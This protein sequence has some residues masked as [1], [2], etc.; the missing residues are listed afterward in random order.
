MLKF[1]QYLNEHIFKPKRIEDR[2]AFLKKIDVEYQESIKDKIFTF[3]LNFAYQYNSDDL[4]KVV[5]LAKK[6]KIKVADHTEE[7]Y[8]TSVNFT[9]SEANIRKLFMLLEG[10]EKEE[11]LDDY[12]RR[13][14][15]SNWVDIFKTKTFEKP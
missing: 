5:R 13:L 8:T 14:G 10:V 7:Q 4:K 6:Y 3:N 2:V 12:C 1:E 15:Y 9:G 11:Y